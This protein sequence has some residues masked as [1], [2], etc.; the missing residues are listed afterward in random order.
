M[1]VK[2]ISIAEFQDRLAVLCP[3]TSGGLPRRQ[4][5]RHIVF[6]SIVQ[7]L[8]VSQPYSEQALNGALKEWISEVGTGFG[9]D[10]VTL[11]RYLVDA[12]YLHRDAYGTSYQ[13]QPNGRGEV[14]FEPEVGQVDPV[15]VVRKARQQ[16][17]ARK[18]A[19]MKQDL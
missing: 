5:D 1:R 18:R 4:R 2:P 15:A 9:V 10:H 8:S 16:A 19:R 17:A 6:R 12:G 14:E 13:V 7:V 3:G 11:R